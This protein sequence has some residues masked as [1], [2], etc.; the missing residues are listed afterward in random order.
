[1]LTLDSVG[2]TVAGRTLFTGLTW[3]VHARERIGLVGPNGSGKTS[4]LRLV[5]G[6]DE[7]DEGRVARSSGLRVAYLPQEVETEIGGDAP[8]LEAALAAA[9]EIRALGDECHRLADEMTDLATRA[10]AD[11]AATERLHRVSDLY[12]E[13]R[14]LFE[15]FGGDQIEA[16][17]RAVL[18]G[19]G[20][21]TDDFARP[22]KTFSGGWRMR[23]L[24]A[25]LLLS[26]ADLLLLDEPTNHLDLDALA[27]LEN[28]LASTPAAML[29]VSHDRVF[30]DKVANRIAD[31][32]RG[33][34]RVTNGGYAAW[35]RAR[36][37]ERELAEKRD[38][39]L[40]K[41]EE[42]LSDFVERFRYK[43]TKAAAA[44]ER[45][46]MLE[47]VREE[48][49]QIEVDPARRFR[50]RWPDPPPAPDLLLRLSGIRKRYGD[51][52]VLENVDLEIRQGQRIALMGPNGAGKTTLLRI[53]NGDLLP[54]GGR[55]EAGAGLLI[56][57]F[58]QHQ[59]EAMDGG[60][61][62]IDEAARGAVGRKPEDVRRALGTLG[63]GDLHVD[64][65]VRT[66]SGGER[67]RLAM[68]RLLLRPSNL[69]LL[70]E[71]TNHLDLPLR[72]ALERALA[73]WPGT[74]L[75]V[76]HDRAFLDKV[77]N[78][79]I[80]VEGGVAERLDG[81]W[82]LWLDW[83]AQR[84]AAA[85][86]AESAGAVHE[87]SREGRRQRAEALQERRRRLRPLEER[88]RSLE[89]AIHEA[90]ERLVAIDA[91]LADPAV[92]ADGAKMKELAQAREVTEARIASLY[93]EWEAAAQ[94]L[95]AEENS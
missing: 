2:R 11:E 92:H 18:G 91:A 90:E 7:P 57:S 81:G 6:L 52:T 13:R 95:H 80:A 75:V 76:S 39:A 44:Q 51:K 43:A 55:R 29:V 64:R 50:F 94:V 58:A 21:A 84:A 86:P 59:L 53:V 73:E 33:R 26:G 40:R 23:A 36:E 19:L 69:L 5:A 54:D 70:D 37:N 61:P 87:R 20:F 60:A 22:V 4:L 49:A 34:L 62:V 41:D 16:K 32:V 74:L 83:R 8:L 68:A 93:P 31:L 10:A 45:L 14:A 66:L 3:T 15:W 1:M 77:T 78:A 12:G 9:G 27:W 28:H 88:V 89:S 72:E 82:S 42:R 35:V 63:L 79:T 38:L 48:R 24:M 30:L 25:R 17:A 65:P 85:A 46:R 47:A 56:G 67:A 71:P